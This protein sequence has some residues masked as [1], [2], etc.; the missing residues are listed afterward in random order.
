M[1][2]IPRRWPVEVESERAQAL[3]EATEATC[4]LQEA[5]KRT[6]NARSK[7][8]AN[9]N[10]ATILLSDTSRS[11]SQAMTCLE[12]IQRFLSVS[13]AKQ[14][15]GRWPIGV[16]KQRDEAHVTA[17]EAMK[18]LMKTQDKARMA[19]DKITLNPGLVETMIADIA[20]LQAYAITLTERINRLLTEAA[21]G[22]D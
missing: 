5:L 3:H 4:Y 22:R 18:L 11:T 16:S 7:V 19:Q 20:N 6:D 8:Y 15:S 9:Q 10:L 17:E 1:P 2:T 14:V 12:R 13:K 21:I